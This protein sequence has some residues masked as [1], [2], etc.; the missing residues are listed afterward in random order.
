MRLPVALSVT[1]TALTATSA[2]RALSECIEYLIGSIGAGAA[3]STST[4]HGRLHR[5]PDLTRRPA[6]P[7]RISDVD[8]PADPDVE[9]GRW[10]DRS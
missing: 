3:A 8:F 9:D 7:D 4:R 6:R 2:N 10:S 1:V 5:K